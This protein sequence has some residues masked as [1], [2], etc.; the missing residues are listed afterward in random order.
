MSETDLLYGVRRAFPPRY[1]VA[2]LLTALLPFAAWPADSVASPALGRVAIKRAASDPFRMQ[3]VAPT[4]L[5]TPVYVPPAASPAPV[6]PSFQLSFL[7]RLQ[8]VDGRTL[9]M[10]QSADGRTFTLEEGKVLSNG[11]R[12]ERI[13]VSV[14]E[15]QHS[16]TQS[17]VQLALPPM[18]RF[19]TR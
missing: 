1:G 15:L 6:A 19:E 12:V 8:A 3:V 9:V 4:P 16:Q 14:V 13:G 7:G 2:L 11:Y 5:P 18:P 10:T 17:V